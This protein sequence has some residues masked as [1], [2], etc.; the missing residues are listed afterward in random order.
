MLNW[1]ASGLLMLTLWLSN[2]QAPSPPTTWPEA[3]AASSTCAV[4]VDAGPDTNVCAPGGLID[5]MGSITGDALFFQWTPYN[6]LSDPFVLDP[7]ADITGPITY[8]LSAYGVDPDNPNLVINGDFSLGNTGFTS[9]YSY[10]ADIP[11]N[12]DEM[13]PEGTYTVINNPN[14]VHWGFDACSDHTGGGGDMLVVNGAASFQDVWCQSVTVDMNSFYNVAA[15]VAS[16]NPASPAELQFSINGT[17]IGPIVNASPS[18]CIWTPFN[19]TWYSGP[20]TTADICIL[21]LNTA[22]GGNDFAIDDISIVELCKV[23]DEVE[24]TLYFE[25]APEPLIDG[26]AILCE[27]DIGV[28]TATF[29]PEPPIYSYQW[30]IPPGATIISGQG[31]PEITVAWNDVQTAE[32]CL[33]IE[34]RCDIN[35]ACFE[36]TVGTIPEFPLITGPA[37]LC[38]GETATFYT[39]ELDPDDIFD[40]TVPPNVTIISGQGT[41]EIMVEWALEGEAEI[42]LEVTNECGS[43]DNCAIITLNPNYT[44]LFDT[45]LCEGS[46]IVINGTTYGNGLFTGTEYF[47]TAAGCDSIVEIEITEATSL[48][49]MQTETLCPGDSIFLAGAYQTDEGI[50]TDSFSTVSGCDSIVITNLIFS[51]FDTTWISN[52]SCNPADTGVVIE[53][54]S[55]GLCDSTVIT[56]TSLVFSDTTEIIQYSCIEADT[57][58]VS[59]LLTNQYNCDS[60]VSVT[61]LFSASDTIAIFQTSCDPLQVGITIDTFTNANGCDSIITTTVSYSQSDTTLLTLYSCTYADTGV[62][63]TLFTNSLDCDSLV[64][65]HTLYGG[66]DTTF[67]NT[68]TCLPA[69]SGYTYTTLLNQHA[70]DSVIALYTALLSSDTTYLTMSSCEPSDTGTTT[71][72]L[73]NVNG[74]DSTVITSTSLNPIDECAIEASLS[75]VQPLCFGDSGIVQIHAEIG[76]APF[77]LQ[78]NHEDMVLNGNSIINTSPGFV[79]L[80]L[81]QPGV[82]FLELHSANGLTWFDT[83]MID[84]I[85]PLSVLIDIP[86]DAF[87]FGV[88]C[89]GD[90]TGAASAV[91][92]EPGSPPYLF[93][94]SDGT[95]DD[96][97]TML[98]AGVYT[99]TV[100]DNHGCVATATSSLTA[101]EPMQYA[102][103][104][105]DISCFGESNGSVTLTN[106]LGGVMPW[107]T[108]LN[109]SPFSNNLSYQLLPGG[110]YN[111]IITDQNGCSFSETFTIEEPEAWSITLGSDTSIVFG[112]SLNL[113]LLISGQPTG[114]LQTEWSDGQC[115]NCLSRIV[116]PGAN[117]R[118]QVTATDENGCTKT[119]D[120]LIDVAIDRNLFIPNVF[121]PNGDQINDLFLLHAGAGLEEIEV[122]S[123]FDRWGNLVFQTSHFHP[124]DITHAWDGT[125]NGEPLNPGVYVYSLTARFQDGLKEMRFGDV[126]LMR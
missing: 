40:W 59:I 84:D 115:S 117:T 74:C 54:Y 14:L 90:T 16:V 2:H 48:E 62:V 94:W 20:N 125:M 92:T 105:N 4:M 109:G 120:I 95:G 37:S 63:E 43:I 103:E 10:V 116:S 102:V 34:T 113:Q 6:G 96:Q 15:W 104:V 57:G 77:D 93:E 50:Y 56:E 41:N 99:L 110:E 28:Y 58:T 25:D 121:S 88:R 106:T 55:Q 39:P 83:L 47:I 7:T 73:M 118:Y 30:T 98:G 64:I 114:Q 108:S 101:P 66:S 23:E 82:Y 26:P 12:M 38:P 81:T 36:V 72:V 71:L 123:I 111:F 8:T 46:T 97:I 3:P 22:A 27:G 67:L 5:L 68:T 13:V 24:I 91:I 42:C 17:P 9:D 80:Y 52:F 124:E 76:L 70:C 75:I 107:Q 31:T 44:T 122:M 79:D 11:G 18:T 61:T 87:G 119:A 85:P 78:W 49:F 21:N 32:L 126:T 100:T 51:A 29:P 86:T 69:D 60:L 1:T 112:N 53:T 89:N 45:I 19:A 35:E 65:V 33:E